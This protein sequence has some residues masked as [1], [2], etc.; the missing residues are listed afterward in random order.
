MQSIATL[1]I[2]HLSLGVNDLD[3]AQRFY[4]DLLG[5]PTT[6]EGEQVSVRWPDFLLVLTLRPPSDRAKFH[7]GFRV[8]SAAEVDTW[9]QRLRAGGAEIISGPST[10]DGLRRLFFLD[11]DGYEVE[12]S[13]EA[14]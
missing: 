2:S 9:A 14:A 5:L 3:E 1:R 8:A 4:G 12:I 6:R 7:F 13:T 11:P 10:N